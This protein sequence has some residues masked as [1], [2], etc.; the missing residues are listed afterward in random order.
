MMLDLMAIEQIK[1]EGA[2]LKEMSDEEEFFKLLER[3]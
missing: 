1:T 3:R 2:K